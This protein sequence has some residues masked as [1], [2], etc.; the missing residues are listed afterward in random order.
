MAGF[1]TLPTTMCASY[2]AGKD[3]SL[4]PTAET[5]KEAPVFCHIFEFR[6]ALVFQEP[7]RHSGLYRTRLA[8]PTTIATFGKL[9]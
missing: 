7:S 5:P 9:K 6:T 3:K 4:T 2:A 1:L 8:G